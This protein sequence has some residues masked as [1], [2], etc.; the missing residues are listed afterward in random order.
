MDHSKFF[1]MFFLATFGMASGLSLGPEMPL[2]VVA[3]MV[4]SFIALKTKQSVLSARVINLTAA[5]AAIGGFFGFP[6]AGALFVLE[7]PHRMGLQYFEALSPSVFAS[8]IAVIVN[9]MVTGKDVNGYFDYPFLTDTLPN[10]VTFTAI[11]Y[12]VYGT[13]VGILY[14]DGVKGLKAWV[15]DWFHAPHDH[16][17]DHGHGHEIAHDHDDGYGGE[18]APLV[19]KGFDDDGH[20]YHFQPAPKKVG[21]WKRVTG[22]LGN[23]FGIKYEPHRAAAAGVL[24]GIVTGIICM[25]LPHQ[26]FWGEAQLQVCKFLF[27]LLA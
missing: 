15:H 3:G 27:I 7:L 11:V 1:H 23:F 19:Q 9:K 21:C 26:L 24:V 8:I 13:F 14:A 4:G 2:V 17:D 6:M 16:H 25:L 12:G 18:K 10:D 5:S 20:G 22:C